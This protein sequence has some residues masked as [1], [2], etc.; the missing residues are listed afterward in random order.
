MKD[1]PE[2]L[3]LLAVLT[4][5][6]TLVLHSHADGWSGE[7]PSDALKDLDRMIETCCFRGKQGLPE[8]WTILYAPTGPLQEIALANGWSD[9]YLRLAAEFDT[10]APW[11]QQN[12]VR[13]PGA[14]HPR[15]VRGGAGR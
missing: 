13:V 11:L 15:A 5:S 12:I 7:A 10:L 1:W 2:T 6:R 3:R 4:A 14:P 8:H 9:A